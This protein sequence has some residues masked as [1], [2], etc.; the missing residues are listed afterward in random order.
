[1]PQLVFANLLTNRPRKEPWLTR[2]GMVG[3]P[4]YLLYAIALGLGLSRS[5]ALGLAL[6]FLLH[7]LFYL[8]STVVG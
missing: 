4:T 5:P 6:F 1:M 8:A 3:R 7:C 2:A